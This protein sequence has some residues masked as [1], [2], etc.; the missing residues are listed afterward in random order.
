MLQK[1]ITVL[2]PN[3][4][5]RPRCKFHAL[6]CFYSHRRVEKNNKKNKNKNHARPLFH[7]HAVVELRSS[8]GGRTCLFSL[9]M[10][11][12]GASQPGQIHG[13]WWKEAWEEEEV[14]EVGS[15]LA[16]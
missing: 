16:P 11:Q 2:P 7:I 4:T 8:A 9:C 6:C 13:G 5:V 14:D 1:E 10:A 3:P 12:T 15:G